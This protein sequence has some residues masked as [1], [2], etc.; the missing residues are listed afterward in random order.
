MNITP[1]RIQ[2]PSS[3]N[4]Y[5]QCPRRYYFTYI[6]K[7]PTKP[8]IHT[9]RGS[10][11]H[12]V[13]E[14]FYDIELAQ[15]D[16]N[17]GDKMIL[18]ALNLFDK[19]WNEASED[20][21]SLNLSDNEIQY[22]Y[23]DS[24]SMI[25]NWVTHILARLN[26]S[27]DDFST[28]FNRI[29]P[30]REQKYV[31]EKYSV[32]GYIDAIEEC[33]GKV[34]LIDYKTSKNDK[35]SE[36]YMLQLGIYALLYNEKHSEYPDEVGLFL[37]KHGERMVKVTEELVSNAKFRIENVHM[38]TQT[39]DMRDYPKKVGPLCNYCDFQNICFPK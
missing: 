19:H 13:L 24:K 32:M 17:V 23:D 31:S 15:D 1:S 6:A 7:L 30:I 5:N 12:T 37:L 18:H 25:I 39:K 33:D 20:L 2:S 22:Y 9:V 28:T 14:N 35:M 4:T 34:R 8:N 16:V 11:V 38:S 27:S 29:K 21:N 3:I 26:S 36:E 10:V